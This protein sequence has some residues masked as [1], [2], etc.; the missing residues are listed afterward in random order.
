MGGVLGLFATTRCTVQQFSSSPM[1]ASL[2]AGSVAVAVPT[3]L[4]PERQ[5]FLRAY[6][7]SVLGVPKTQVGMGIII[8]SSA[9]S[10][11][12]TF[13]LADYTLRWLSQ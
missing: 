5:Q 10:G 1:L 9:L 3:A 4:V 11:A 2:V 12:C 8:A 6:F 7:A 13:G